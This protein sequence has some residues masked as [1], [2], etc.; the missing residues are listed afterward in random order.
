[1]AKIPLTID[2][3]YC[4]NWGAWHGIRELLQN[5]ADAQDHEG[6][7]MTVKHRGT[8]VEIRTSNAYVEP[9]NLLVLGR[10]SK[11]DGGQRGKFGEGFVLGVLALVRKG[12]EVRFR[13]GEMSWSAAFERA[14][15]GHPLEGNELLTFK[16][17]A[18]KLR[19]PDFVVEIEGISTEAWELIKDK[20]LFLAP[21]NKAD[22]IETTSG[23]LLLN[24][25][26]RGEVFVRG[27]FVRSFDDLACG[28]DLRDAPLDRDRQ[29]I[30]EWELHYQL[31][32]AWTEACAENPATS[33][34]W[35]YQMARDNAP[36]ARQVKYHAGKVLLENLRSRFACDYGEDAVPVATND[37]AEQ[38]QRLGGKPAM[39]SSVLRELLSQGGLTVEAAKKRLE[40]TVVRRFTPENVRALGGL[41][42]ARLGMIQALFGPAIVVEY[43]STSPACHPLDEKACLGVDFRLLTGTLRALVSAAAHAEA[44]RTERQPVDVLLDCVTKGAL[45]SGCDAEALT[46]SA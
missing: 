33:G 30:N 4:A 16:S 26:H 2:K 34:R 38:V 44:Q 10:T 7:A 24:P 21:P 41:A 36:D 28:Y 3:N 32:R 35:L 27:L 40:S 31:G 42:Y 23:T 29:M 15:E 43:N 17:R 1:M 45:Q 39:V 14:D 18:L 6:K 13:N 37:E 25:K 46:P 9:A 8:A 11:A 5:A 12:C 20:V 22:T 19:E